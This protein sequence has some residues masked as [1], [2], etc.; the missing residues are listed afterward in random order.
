MRGSDVFAVS[1]EPH[2]IPELIRA[3]PESEDDDGQRCVLI[4]VVKRGVLE[5]EPC[6][7]LGLPVVTVYNM[8]NFTIEEFDSHLAE[9]QAE[10][11]SNETPDSGAES[12]DSGMTA[13]MRNA[14]RQAVSKVSSHLV[15]RTGNWGVQDEH[16]A[17]NYLS[18]KYPGAYGL[19]AEAIMASKRFQGISFVSVVP[20]STQRLVA[21]NFHFR[22]RSSDVSEKYQCVVDV[23]HPFPFMHSSLRAVYD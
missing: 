6:A 7:A 10:A 2:V 17:A 4:G 22:G 5:T 8:L 18:V 14:L 19:V 15:E 20:H 23:T 3:L 21:V 13:N 16:R 12:D 11:L 1:S 9:Y